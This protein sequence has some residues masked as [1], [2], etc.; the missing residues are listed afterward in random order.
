MDETIIRKYR[1][2]FAWQDKERE[3]WLEEMSRSGLHLKTP[4]RFGGYQFTAAPVQEYAYRL[5][6]QRGKPQE[7]YLQLIQDAGWEYLGSRA[8][9]HYWRKEVVD[10]KV[11]EIFTDNTSKI[12][13]YQR[14]LASFVTS[15]PVLYI[16]GLAAI[17]QFPGR[18]PGWFVGLFIGL[19]MAYIVFALVNSLMIL[20][21]INNLKK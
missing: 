12:Q 1:F 19:F 5:D 2:F 16:L 18:H 14:L 6:F 10:G 15:A 4:G 7:D 21:R 8:G 11:E 13:M 20:K 17:K 9:W 3:A